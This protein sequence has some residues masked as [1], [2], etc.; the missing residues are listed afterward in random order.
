MNMFIH[1]NKSQ[2]YT[3]T[4]HLTIS[5][6]T[7]KI[8]ARCMSGGMFANIYF[9]ILLWENLYNLRYY[10]KETKHSPPVVHRRIP[11]SPGFRSSRNSYFYFLIKPFVSS[12]KSYFYMMSKINLSSLLNSSLRWHPPFYF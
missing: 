4:S 5:N 3:Y 6:L 10:S 2:I 8:E 7:H 12:M 9:T 11:S 1:L